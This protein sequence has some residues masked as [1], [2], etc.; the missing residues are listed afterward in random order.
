MQSNNT[1]EIRGFT[2]K[3]MICIVVLSVI[4]LLA[5]VVLLV[6]CDDYKVKL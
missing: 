1:K 6:S 5:S 3:Q 2:K 4:L